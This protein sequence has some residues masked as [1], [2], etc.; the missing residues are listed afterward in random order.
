MWA[1]VEWW[2]SEGYRTNYESPGVH[3]YTHD[4]LRALVQVYQRSHAY[5]TEGRDLSGLGKEVLEPALGELKEAEKGMS[6]EGAFYF[7][8]SLAV[9]IAEFLAQ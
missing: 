2:I 6:K 7:R 4:D 5:N 8:S 3:E 1:R 9:V